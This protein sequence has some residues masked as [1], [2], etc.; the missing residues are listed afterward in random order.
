MEPLSAGDSSQQAIPSIRTSHWGTEFTSKP[1]LGS[2]PMSLPGNQ[3][4]TAASCYAT[5]SIFRKCKNR[6]LLLLH[7]PHAVLQAPAM[8]SPVCP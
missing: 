2:L 1:H 5:S 7:T 4:Y 3:S 6:F 8:L